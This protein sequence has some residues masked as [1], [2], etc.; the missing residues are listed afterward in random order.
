MPVKPLVKRLR[1]ADR[2][3][4]QARRE[5]LYKNR[6]VFVARTAF[7]GGRALDGLR[8]VSETGRRDTADIYG[9]IGLELGEKENKIEVRGP[10]Q[11]GAFLDRHLN[12]KGTVGVVVTEC[13]NDGGAHQ[14]A[15]LSIEGLPAYRKKFIAGNGGNCLLIDTAFTEGGGPTVCSALATGEIDRSVDDWRRNGRIVVA[16]VVKRKKTRG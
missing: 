4:E 11:L 2:V 10:G 8:K 14:V 6:C 15:V 16:Q 7:G 9:E 1:E 12:N 5:G 13:D 3:D